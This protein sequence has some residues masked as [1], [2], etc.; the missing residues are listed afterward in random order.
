VKISYPTTGIVSIWVGNFGSEHEFDVWVDGPLVKAL[1][2]EP[3]S[4]SICEVSYEEEPVP[5]CKL[6]EGFSGWESF[7]G[8]AEAVAKARNVMAANAA[9]VCYY[10]RCEEAPRVWDKVQFLG[11]FAGQ[12]V[13]SRH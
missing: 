9:L 7:A 1:H 10:V 8:Q 6:L 3:P 12:D 2:I 13:T 4:A 5:I 11:S